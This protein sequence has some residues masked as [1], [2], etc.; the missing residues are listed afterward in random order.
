MANTYVAIATVTV[1]SGGAA[2]I[3]FTSIP[4]TFTDLCIYVSARDAYTISGESTQLRIR[5]NGDSTNVYSDRSL[6]GTGSSAG[7]NNRSSQSYVR[8]TSIDTSLATASTFGNTF[9]YIPNYT[10]SNNKSISFDGVTENNATA[11][12]AELT[13]G[14]WANS[15]A[16]SSIVISSQSGSNFV[17]YST[18]TLY[19]IKNS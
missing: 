12:I 8:N 19:G 3:D 14:L 1:G 9:I 11:A 6:Y 10:S 17:Q 7:S 15:A 18:A 16:I 13:A 4:A 5:F 2:S